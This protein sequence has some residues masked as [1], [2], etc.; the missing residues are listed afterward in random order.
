[1]FF[2]GILMVVLLLFPQERLEWL[3]MR[4]DDTNLDLSI[5]YIENLLSVNPDD[6][7]KLSLAKRYFRLAEYEKMEKLLSELE[8]SPLDYIRVEAVSLRYAMLKRLYFAGHT[9]LKARIEEELRK[10]V[11][12]TDDTATLRSLYRESLSM[13]MPHVAL[14]VAEKL[15]RIAVNKLHWLE[16]AYRQAIATGELKKAVEF[17]HRLSRLDRRK[18]AYWLA[19][20]IRLTIAIKDYRLAEDY[21]KELGSIRKDARWYDM[22]VELYLLKG[23][24]PGA[25]D[26]CLSALM[27]EKNR[28]RRFHYLKKALQIA[29]WNDDY[30]RVK[31]IIARYGGVFLDDD[32]MAGFILKSALQ[33]GDV[34][35]ARNVAL[36]ILEQFE[37]RIIR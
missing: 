24:Y 33:T 11:E 18:R 21:L 34:G 16:E 5:T 7:M 36:N 12:G 2:L 6:R 3:I 22:A 37:R 25:I 29:M 23:D 26:V 1:M 31:D 19:E 15:S 10:A 13:A 20:A 8:D 27:R 32:E 9:E 35:F 28:K 30:K 4:E 14:I 17:A